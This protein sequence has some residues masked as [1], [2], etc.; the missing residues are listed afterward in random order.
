[1]SRLTK[2]IEQ[3]KRRGEQ[4]VVTSD[5]N[6]SSF[7][8]SN[9]GLERY[10]PRNST[11]EWSSNGGRCISC[12]NTYKVGKLVTRLPHL[13]TGIAFGRLRY[14]YKVCIFCSRHVADEKIQLYAI[15]LK[16]WGFRQK[17]GL[18]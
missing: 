16:E 7:S 3:E 9:S 18:S 10:V 15:P 11:G 8:N 2:L 5:S 12:G 17:M 4:R 14:G 13:I 1:M 6:C